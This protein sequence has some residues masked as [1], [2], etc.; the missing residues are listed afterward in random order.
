VL[1]RLRGWARA[2]KTQALTIYFVARDA[3]TPWWVR[4]LAWLVAAYAFSPI[5]L[6]PDFI[7]VLGMLDDLLLVPLGLMLVLRLAPV[8]V[9][10][11]ARHR[12]ALASERPVS[13]AMAV[14]IV[15]VWVGLLVWGLTLGAA[16]WRPLA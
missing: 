3:R 12:A 10:A 6:I 15:L 8:D 13:R 16:L 7:P 5:D 2:L 9:V 1:E 11:E 14:A 4:A